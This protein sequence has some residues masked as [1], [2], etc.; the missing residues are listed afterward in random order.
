MMVLEKGP[1]DVAL[2]NLLIVTI[3]LGVM[4]SLQAVLVLL[5]LNHKVCNKNSIKMLFMQ[6]RLNSEV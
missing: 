1:F 4:F 3:C 6:F 2:T 5:T